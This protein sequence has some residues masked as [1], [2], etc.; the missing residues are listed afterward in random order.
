MRIVMRIV[1]IIVMMNLLKRGRE[2]PNAQ[3]AEREEESDV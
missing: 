3:V 1:T 2:S